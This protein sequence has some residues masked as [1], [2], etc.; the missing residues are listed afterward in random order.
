MKRVLLLHP[1][2]QD[3]ID[4]IPAQYQAPCQALGMPKSPQNRLP[5]TH[6]RQ[7]NLGLLPCCCSKRE[8]HLGEVWGISTGGSLGRISIEFAGLKLVIGCS[9]KRLVRIHKPGSCWNNQ[10]S[11]LEDTWLCGVTGR[12]VCLWPYLEHIWYSWDICPQPNIMF[13]KWKP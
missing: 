13:G 2:V 9:W 12:S 3:T 6:Q 8:S 7:T 1:F 11:Y 4:W 5:G 10:C